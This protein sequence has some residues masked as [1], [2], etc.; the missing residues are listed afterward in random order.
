[1]E[2]GERVVSSLRERKKWSQAVACEG[3]VGLKM[4][5]V[6]QVAEGMH[7]AAASGD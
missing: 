2:V 3:R 4:L 6:T 1:M 5:S 7:A